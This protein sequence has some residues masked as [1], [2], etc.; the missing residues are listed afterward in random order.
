VEKPEL[1][2]SLRPAI[3]HN[4]V[5]TAPYVPLRIFSCYTMLE[6]AIDPKAI[7]KQAKK[8]D[9]P[10]AAVTD[11]N[12][13]YGAMPFTDACL[14]EGVQ[15]IV[16]TLLGVA[17]PGTPE[18]KS[19]IIDWLPLYAQDET[20]YRNL[21][22][23][24]SSAHLDR[25]VEDTAHVS[26]EKLEGRTEGLIALTGGGEGALARLIAEGQE[27]A[28]EALADRL[29]TLF[30]GRLYVEL[31]RRGDP[32][33]QAAETGLIELAY[34]RNLPLV[35]T[36]PAAYLDAAF[37]RA[38]DAMLCIAQSSQLDRDDRERSS[39]ETWLKPAAEMRTLFA[40]LPEAIENSAV[41]ARRCGFGAPKRKPILPRTAGDV[42]EEA[43]QLRRDARAGLAQRLSHY[44]ELSEADRQAYADRLEY[45]LDVIAGMGFPGYFLIVADFIKWAKAQGIP[46][47]PGRG[48]GAGSVVA[49]ALTIT[50][51]DPMRLGLLFERFLN[52]ER[53]SMPDFYIDF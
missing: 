29:E 1:A 14:A 16:G 28:A 32:V 50:D 21:C 30:P 52:P 37:H 12:G 26:V 47:G 27:P 51:L 48:S 33:E 35:A 45:E 8:L 49:W 31:S 5:M 15:P 2:L 20:G 11:R 41:I 23:L 18:G 53:V 39:T 22:A 43:E 4:P 9:F 13:L 44:D 38:H 3:S 34:S 17:R 25:P 24:V 46:V 6:G 19:P 36:N 7:A 40:D 42:E 10:A